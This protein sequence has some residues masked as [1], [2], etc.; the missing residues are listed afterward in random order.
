MEEPAAADER[1][2]ESP[3]LPALLQPFARSTTC[4]L[5]LQGLT[6]LPSA[7]G[8][9][10][11][12]T[13]CHLS[14]NAL[15]ALPREFGQLTAL[16]LCDLSFNAL[17]ALPRE[18]GQLT[19]LAKC[20]LSSNK[21]T[22]LPREFG[23][24]RALAECNLRNNELAALP[25]EFGRLTALTHCNLSNNKLTA[26]PR[27]FGQLGALR[28]CH[29]PNNLLTALPREFGRLTALRRF[30][31][32]ALFPQPFHQQ[33]A[34]HEQAEGN[35]EGQEE[36]QQ[37]KRV[38]ANQLSPRRNHHAAVKSLWHLSGEAV[39]RNELLPTGLLAPIPY[40]PFAWL[41]SCSSSASLM[42]RT[43]H[44]Q[45]T[46][47]EPREEGEG[48]AVVLPEEVKERLEQLQ[49]RCDVCA[50]LFLEA[51]EEEDGG[52][53]RQ[54]LR[55]FWDQQRRVWWELLCCSQSCRHRPLTDL[56]DISLMFTYQCNGKREKELQGTRHA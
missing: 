25:R 51:E 49:R 3:A 42:E 56:V 44:Q 29:L 38:K 32:D 31:L 28:Y 12:L 21:L 4:D 22:C 16:T 53:P 37:K 41:S 26:L 20:N 11:A 43:T 9:L 52:P 27:E 23:Q 10:R 55:R 1:E 39:L 36:K 7:V 18:F 45:G 5:S 8:R 35:D 54:I 24:L 48:G 50:Q 33:D 13:A 15:S 17:S 40:P 14:H 30:V 47:E 2:E 19:A 34:L 6:S 46:K